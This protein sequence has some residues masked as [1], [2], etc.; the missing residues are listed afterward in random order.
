MGFDRK[1]YDRASTRILVNFQSG[2]PITHALA[3]MQE[4]TGEG[5]TAYT[6]KALAEKLQKD[7]YLSPDEPIVIKGPGRRT[8]ELRLKYKEPDYRDL[9][10]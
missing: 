5:Y 8:H 1:E 7:G 10:D 3:E 6:K 2:D 4:R 9:L